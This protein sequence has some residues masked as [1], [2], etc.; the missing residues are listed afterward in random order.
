MLPLEPMGAAK[1][2]RGMEMPEMSPRWLDE[3]EEELGLEDTPAPDNEQDGEISLLEAIKKVEFSPS[4]WAH[5]RGLILRAEETA[6]PALLRR[7]MIDSD[8]NT[9]LFTAM[10]ALPY[11][12]TKSL[13]YDKER[14]EKLL[15]FVAASYVIALSKGYEFGQQDMIEERPSRDE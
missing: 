15:A 2:G 14:C 5:V 8:D 4:G 1:S 6:D 9:M 11:H 13:G 10:I 3:L 7:A 12:L